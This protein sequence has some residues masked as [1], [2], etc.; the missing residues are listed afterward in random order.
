MMILPFVTPCRVANK[1]HKATARLKH[2]LNRDIQPSASAPDNM[3]V[4]AYFRRQRNSR[5]LY[6]AL[7]P[8]DHFL[9]TTNAPGNGAELWDWKRLHNLGSFNLGPTDYT[10]PVS[11]SPDSKLVALI[12]GPFTANF[13]P[14]VQVWS[15]ATRKPLAPWRLGLPT[16]NSQT[17]YC[18]RDC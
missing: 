1:P 9:V 3:I 5:I 15:V 2:R 4:T 10:Q 8:N 16:S 7:S 13:G 14:V 6:L 12:D 18:Y 11:F 17:M